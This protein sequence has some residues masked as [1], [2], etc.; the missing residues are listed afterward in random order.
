ML[1]GDESCLIAFKIVFST[2][3]LNLRAQMLS[4]GLKYS[5]SSHDSAIEKLEL[6]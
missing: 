1:K 6:A 2:A 4:F 5:D 3:L